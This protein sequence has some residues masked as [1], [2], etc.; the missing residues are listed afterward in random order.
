MSQFVSMAE[1]VRKGFDGKDIDKYIEK[2]ASDR[3][4]NNNERQRLIEEVNIGTFLD[5]LQDGSH[6]EDFDVASPVISHGN[7]EKPVLDSSELS[8]SASMSQWETTPL[9]FDIIGTDIDSESQMLQK[10]AS[11]ELNLEI[12]NSEDKWKDADAL[13]KEVEHDLKNG[14]EKNAEVDDIYTSL[15]KVTRATNMSEGMVKTAAA[16]LAMND[17]DELAIT[18]IENSKYSSIE[19]AD[20]PAE[21]LSKQASSDMA[22]LLRKTS[23]NAISDGIKAAKGL[24][25]IVVYPIKHPVVAA[26]TVGTGLYLTSDRADKPDR[27]RVEMSLRS[28]NNG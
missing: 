24:K 16:V 7:G 2:Y 1:D 13:R 17:L 11:S 18:L 26:G 22:N 8:K 25:D 15:S 23:K 14:L 21:E 3:G 12:M 5:K 20:A 28:F 6:Y 9:M 19:V 27:D 4:L 10:A